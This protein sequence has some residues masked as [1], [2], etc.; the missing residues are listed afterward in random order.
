LPIS[1]YIKEQLNERTPELPA[2]IDYSVGSGHFLTE[3]MEEYQRVIEEDIDASKLETDDAETFVNAWRIN[4]YDWA[5][6][7]VYGIEKDYRL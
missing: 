5:S 4:K 6:K 1:K 7:Y 2:V 3:V